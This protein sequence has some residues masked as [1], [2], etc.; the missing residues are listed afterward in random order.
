[1]ISNLVSKFSLNKRLTLLIPYFLLAA[2]FIIAPLILLIVKSASPVSDVVTGE[3]LD[4]WSPI[5]DGETWKIMWRS[6]YSGIIAGIITMVIGIPFAY[7][8]SRFNSKLYKTLAIALMISPLF[9]FTIAKALSLRGVLLSSFDEPSLNSNFVSI[10]GMA[11]LYLPFM[12]IPVYSVFSTMPKSLLEASHDL[13]DHSFS[14]L[15]KVVLPYSLRGIV[16]GFAVVFMMS[17]TSIVVSDKLLPSGFKQQTIGNLINQHSNLA[18]PFD[19]AKASTISLITIFVM[20]SV[21][22]LIYFVP[23]LIVKLKGGINV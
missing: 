16:S 22:G 1:M 4:N 15:I 8:V 5:K 12:I 9:V 13:G 6:I 23:Q 18:N 2:I 7:I 21:Y 10:I 17:A 3:T 20:I 14:T 19:I 11:Y